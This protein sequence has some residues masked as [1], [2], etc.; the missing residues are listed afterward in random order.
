MPRSSL[1]TAPV[2]TYPLIGITTRLDAENTFYLRRYYA[3]AIEAFGGIPVYIPLIPDPKYL[4]AVAEKIEGLMLSGSDSDIDPL[5]YGEEPHPKLG[6]V[7]PERD[8]T[9]L[10][11]LE[12]AEKRKMPVLAICFGIQSLNVSRGGTLIQDIESQTS[13]LIKHEQGRVYD[14]PSHHIGI[15]S[16][17]LLAKLAGGDSARVNSSHHQSIKQVGR[18]LRVVARAHDGVI[19]A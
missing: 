14:S 12:A 10:I 15:E 16:N 3:E 5:F 7:V 13:N 1:S 17:S 18:D 19:E 4:S 11:L 6:S 2:T 9:D 8:Q